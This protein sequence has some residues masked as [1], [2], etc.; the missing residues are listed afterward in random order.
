M[1]LMDGK[2]VMISG[3]ARGQGRS[4]AVTMAR[5]GAD[6]VIFDVCEDI[7][8]SDVPQAT[9]EDLDTTQRM[10]EDLDRRCIAV[11]ADA[12]STEQVEAVVARALEDFGKI[13]AV[14][15]NH[16]IPTY[17]PIWETS[18]EQFRAQL[19]VNCLSAFIVAKAVIPQ[20]IERGEGGSIVIT[21]SGAGVIAFGNLGAYTAAKHGVIGLM[22]SLALEL[23]PYMIRANAI[24]PGTI[25]TPMI[26][27]PNT[28]ELMAGGRKGATWEEIAPLFR[29]FAQKMPIDQLEPE[30]ISNALLYLV[31]DLGRYTTG[32]VMPVDAGAVIK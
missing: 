28:Y 8:Y 10:V 18:E 22:R 13:D 7:E 4:H 21:S 5:E 6:V 19:D 3:G 24:C 11:K 20:M 25:N 15:I 29:Q 17:A 1:G 23:A 16:G 27:H 26:H 32:V 2:V 12:R 30:D 31:S 9:Q 14:S